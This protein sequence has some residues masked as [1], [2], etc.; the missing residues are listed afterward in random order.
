MTDALVLR[1]S[2]YSESTLIVWLLTRDEGVVRVLAK[3]ARRLKG[4]NAA[5][6]DLMS[7]VRVSLRMPAREGLGILRS[8]DLIESWP[9]LRA[10]LNRF[11]FASAALEILGAVASIS[12]HEPYF[13]DDAVHYLRRLEKAA[14][15][16]SLT[17]LL[18]LR[19]LH[20]AGHPPQIEG[21]IARESLPSK[22]AYDFADGTIRPQP[23]GASHG[24][25]WFLLP[26][27]L[28]ERLAPALRRPPKLDAPF[29]VPASEGAA[30]LRWLI[31][32]WEDHLNQ[33]FQ[34]AAFLEQVVLKPVKSGGKNPSKK[35]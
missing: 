24:G 26:K 21:A 12:T 4:H 2:P 16:G 23:T 3:G 18:L 22:L 31:R 6:L 5:A 20:H 32:I 17:A 10:D 9:F 25:R 14:A 8:V 28:V 34:S 19:L 13:F 33:S 7:R 11:A 1:T 29:S 30:L 27:T 35:S 15:P